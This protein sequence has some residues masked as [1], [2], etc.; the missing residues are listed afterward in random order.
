MGFKSPKKYWELIRVVFV[1]LLKFI[2]VIL[3]NQMFIRSLSL[4][5]LLEFYLVLIQ[6]NQPHMLNSMYRLEKRSLKISQISILLS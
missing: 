3:I 5:F 1:L 2:D 6:R 4:Y